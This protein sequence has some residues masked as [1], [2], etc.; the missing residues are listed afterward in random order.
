MFKKVIPIFLACFLFVGIT[1]SSV[2][3]KI[4]PNVI[5]IQLNCKRVSGLFCYFTAWL[6]AYNSYRYMVG[7]G[8]PPVEIRGNNRNTTIVYNPDSFPK[9]TINSLLSGM[10]AILSFYIGSKFLLT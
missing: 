6:L 3:P 8:R 1:K 9:S 2:E 7:D 10:G 4:D 5:N